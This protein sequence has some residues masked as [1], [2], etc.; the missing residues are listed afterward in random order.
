MTHVVPPGPG[1]VPRAMQ[2]AAVVI[3]TVDRGEGDFV[4]V[5]TADTVTLKKQKTTTGIRGIK[6]HTIYCAI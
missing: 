4:V 1:E 6:Y 5:H 2:A 3:V